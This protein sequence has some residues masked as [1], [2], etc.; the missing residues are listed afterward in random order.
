MKFFD[1]MLVYI[2][3][4][5]LVLVGVGFFTLLERKVLG[6]VGNRKGPNKVMLLGLGQPLVDGVKLL[7]KEFIIP[8]SSVYLVFMLCPLFIIL[9]SLLMWLCLPLINH[10]IDFNFGLLFFLCI[11]GVSVY[12]LIFSGWS[13]N[14]K[15]S[16]FGSYRGVA[17]TI[18]YEVSLMLVMMSFIMITGSYNLEL[19]SV[20]QH[21][22][23]MIVIMM[24]L[25]MI[26]MVSML[27]ETNRTPFDFT[28]GESELVSGFNV[29]YSGIMFVF[30]FIGEYSSIMFMSSLFVILFLGGLNY[31]YMFKVLL[32]IMLFI[33]IRG[34]LP[35]FRYDNL[36]YL[37]W[38][39]Y[40]PL[41]INFLFFFLGYKIFL[42]M[43]L[44]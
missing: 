28:E 21:N 11:I 17:Q 35:R 33:V 31:I 30:I 1:L 4:I 29:E 32:I 18:S 5:L 40:L 3:M 6:Y 12:A 44:L 13:S 38:K 34:T 19:F 43:Y 22:I 2:L 7:S 10:F 24:P 25:G 8:F 20:Y 14:S 42:Y 16:I 39:I 26:W 36:M 41:S 27:A 37:A 15:Y 9:L 23:W